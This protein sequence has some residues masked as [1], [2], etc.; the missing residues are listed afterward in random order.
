MNGDKSSPGSL[1]NCSVDNDDVE[2]QEF[3]DFLN[4][5]CQVNDAIARKSQQNLA[6]SL[7]NKVKLQQEIDFNE[8]ANNRLIN[9]LYGFNRESKEN[10][11]EPAKTTVD[12]IK[13]TTCN[14][15]NSSVNS[16]VQNIRTQQHAIHQRP[17][18]VKLSNLHAKLNAKLDFVIN[19]GVLDSVLPYICP[20]QVPIDCKNR[21]KTKKDVTKSNIEMLNV[22]NSTTSNVASSHPEPEIIT[23]PVIVDSK[24]SEHITKTETIKSESQK[25][26]E[27]VIHVCD[28]AKKVSCDF[29]CPKNLLVSKMGY[30]ADVTAG[31]K[32]EEMDIS[33]HCEVQIFEW[34]IKWVKYTN[35]IEHEH[36]STTSLLD[37]GPQL[38]ASNVIQILVSAS[39]LQMEPLIQDCLSYCH[40]H[41]SEVVRTANNLACLNDALIIRLAAM[42]TN[43]ELEKVRDKKERITPRLWT[44]FIQSLCEPEPET[45]RGHYY[46]LSGL[47]RCSR[48]GKCLTNTSK[49]YI[50]CL[51]S[52]MRLNRW[53]QL[54]SYHVRDATWDINAYIIQL[55][56]E[57]KSWRKVY[58]KLW[59][60]CHFLYCCICEMYFP[61]YQL[62]W[63][64][65]HTEGPNFFGP[66][67]EGPVAGPVGRYPC[68]SQ[69][70]F[71]F[72]TLPGPNG[73]QFR[74]HSV[75]VETE[76][77]RSIL[78]LTQIISDNYALVEN[79]PIK[80]Q[81]AVATGGIEPRWMGIPLLPQRFRQGLLPILKPEESTAKLQRRSRQLKSY[82]DA[83]SVES[84]DSTDS[85]VQIHDNKSFVR[86]ATSYCGFASSSDGCESECRSTKTMRF[87]KM[88]KRNKELRGRFWSG[89][90]SARSNQ[91]HQREFEE[92]VMAQV[93]SLMYKKS[94]TD[95][96][97]QQNCLPQGG[98]YVRLENEWKENI[99]QRT[100]NNVTINAS[101]STALFKSKNK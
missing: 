44:K 48:C 65:Y 15:R 86:N 8:L 22:T 16:T 78:S 6:T 27:V 35:A 87:K 23:V 10:F 5:S 19:E 81:E 49:S 40:S 98:S 9:N 25:E 88:K 14:T 17:D 92:R 41:L 61:V 59:G 74:E 96:T 72:E 38:D 54:V 95:Q 62:A 43:E 33:V 28:E 83:S 100:V 66:M 70:A 21:I 11:Q 52:N 26:A 53:G 51:P 85:E 29:Y 84:S 4:V 71:R 42:F 60:H 82:F 97:M 101:S 63:C 7:P 68:C 2:L 64:R 32:L 93:T 55:F 90:L 77:E 46:S 12:P 58:W 91:D 50:T 73:C 13:S 76:R 3:L 34:L 69:Q 80:L 24:E 94:A 36:P 47:F 79:P 31:Q 37:P 57:F 99:K 20:V 67:S 18:I 45:L 1:I 39:F 89:D 56:K 75:I 30:F